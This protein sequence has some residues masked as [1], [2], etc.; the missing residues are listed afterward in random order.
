MIFKKNEITYQISNNRGYVNDTITKS[1]I[2]GVAA[3]I[4]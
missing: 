1:N 2:F 4:L 3:E